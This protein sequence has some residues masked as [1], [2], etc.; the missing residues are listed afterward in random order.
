MKFVY[1]KWHAP[2]LTCAMI[3][4]LFIA[5][6]IYFYFHLFLQFPVFDLVTNWNINPL[7]FFVFC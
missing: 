3:I 1:S 2:V 7:E 5:L 4:P 6:H